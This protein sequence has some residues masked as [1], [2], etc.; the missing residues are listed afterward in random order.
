MILGVFDNDIISNIDSLVKKYKNLNLE[1]SVTQMMI[2]GIKDAEIEAT[3]VKQGYNTETIKETINTTKSNSA[4]ASEI[5][6]TNVLTSSVKKLTIAKKALNIAMSVFGG[7]IATMAFTAIIEGITALVNK[8]KELAEATRQATQE[9]NESNNTI[10]DYVDKYKDLHDALINAGEDEEES[11]NIKKQILDLQTELN[12]KYGEEYGKINLIG[13]AYSDATEK[14]KKYNKELAQSYLNDNTEGIEQAKK[15]MT[16]EMSYNLSDTGINA[17]T[18]E[19]Q[20]LKKIVEEFGRGL[21]LEYETANDN[22]FSISITADPQE[23]YDTINDFMSYLR[24]KSKDLGDENLFD[25]ILER[26]SS[27]LNNAKSIIDEYGEQYQQALLN[28]IITDDSLNK[29]YEKLIRYVNDYNEAVLKS[30]NPYSDENVQKAA[31]NLQKYEDILKNDN[32]Y[33]NYGNIIDEVLNEADRRIYNFINDFSN[34]KYKINLTNMTGIS[35]IDKTEFLSWYDSSSFE[36]VEFFNKIMKEYDVSIEEVADAL[37]YLDKIQEETFNESNNKEIKGITEIISKL[38]EMSEKWSEVDN[39]YQTFKDE[40]FK[41]FDAS[42]LQKIADTF[43]EISDVNIEDFLSVLSNPNSS[44]EEVQHAF[45]VLAAEFVYASGCL[46]DLTDSNADLIAKELE[47]RGVTDANTIV[48]NHLAASKEYAAYS[49]KNL[50]DATYEEINAFINE[51]TASDM[52]KAAISRYYLSKIDANNLTLSTSGD[53]KNIM[54]LVEACGKGVTALTAFYKAKKGIEEA[55]TEVNKLL[56]NPVNITL[57]KN[58]KSSVGE[59]LTQQFN[60]IKQE[61]EN[62]QKGLDDAQKEINDAMNFGFSYSGDTDSNNNNGG[63]GSGS[64][65]QEQEPTVFDWMQQKI[66]ILNNEIEKL[67]D[68][69]DSVVGYK[70]KN[71]YADDSIKK[72]QEEIDLYNQMIDKYQERANTIGLSEEYIQKIKEGTLQIEDVSDEDLSNKI[73]DYQDWQD[74]IENCESSIKDLLKDIE[75]MQYQKLDNIINEYE[76]LSSSISNCIDT[77]DQLISLMEQA[78]EEITFEDYDSLAK[79]QMEIMN[80]N[81]KYY[82][83]LK[84]EMNK[85]NLQEGSEEWE[86]YNSQLNEFKQNIISGAQAIEDYKDKIFELTFKELDN[87]NSKLEEINSTISVMHDLIGDVDLITE[88]GL[89]DRGLAQVALYAQELANAQKQSAEYTNAMDALDEALDSGLITQEEYNEALSEYRAGQESAVQAA[90]E[91]Q[92]A[93]INIIKEGIQAQI[94]AKQ[95]EIE[96]TKEQLNAEKEL[97]DYRE[98]ITDK[99][100]QIAVLQKQIATL[101]LSTAR[102]DIAKRLELEEQL[103]DLQKELYDEQADKALEDQQDA[104]DEELENYTEIKEDEMEELESNLDKQQE[105]I[106]EYLDKVQNNYS[107]VYEILKQ[108]G[109]SYNLS[110]LE[111]LTNPWESGSDAAFTCSEAIGNVCSDINYSIS[112]IDT[113]PIY[114]LINAFKDLAEQFKGFSSSNGYQDVTSQGEWHKNDTGWWYGNSDDDYVSDGIYTINGKQYGFNKDGY[115]KTGWHEIDGDWYYFEPENGQLVKSTWRQDK[116]GDWYYLTSNGTMATNSAIK[117]QS[118]DGYYYVNDDGKWDGLELTEEEIKR[119]GYKVAYK[120]GTKNAKKGIALTDEEGLGSEVI[121]TKYGALR[122]LDSGDNVFNAEQVKNLHELSSGN[123]SQSMLSTFTN[124]IKDM[125]NGFEIN[126]DFR[127]INITSPLIAIDGTGL[128]SSEVK[129]VIKDEVSNLPDRIM[130]AIKYNLR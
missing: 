12:D 66:E 83:A 81:A 107:T 20:E 45:D 73:Q 77:Q 46:D 127:E 110:A 13:D 91:A 114:N 53:V 105:A 101:S 123:M 55:Q 115:M 121:I 5:G 100:N 25:F 88:E 18:K 14:I 51:S 116:K 19:G 28:E 39:L 65:D 40:E 111:D 74:E 6:M 4:K 99:S 78:G 1:Q 35:D 72:M 41:A 36:D 32:I 112:N 16:K 60:I 122:Q 117:S 92:S 27:E 129:D 7:I 33:E 59:Q 130:K 86:E 63:G 38:D 98:S 23:A 61:S 10:S 15:K 52:A 22:I 120:K 104:L 95:E 119:L 58:P 2:D 11:Y 43:Q 75:E 109:D 64:K 69:M 37:V 97:N 54:N 49:G 103:A 108:Y 24:E 44:T 79:K 48:M 29:Q 71:T 94:D 9:F 62:I 70:N 90:K 30:E 93:I 96:A 56:S 118:S 47:L 76:I 3:L 113:S 102:E 82:D 57:A 50:V 106:K 85:L 67:K 80:L 124:M 87:F 26:S 21:E 68:N 42:E 128:S 89:T 126:K 8:E 84:E 31:E 125:F 17:V 34:G